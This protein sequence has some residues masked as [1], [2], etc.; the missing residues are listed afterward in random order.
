MKKYKEILLEKD[1]R[2]LLSQVEAGKRFEKDSLGNDS[3]HVTFPF[4]KHDSDKPVKVIKPLHLGHVSRRK[5][6][7]MRGLDK[8]YQQA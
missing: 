4:V 6:T 8:P 2:E 7:T 1:I 5:Y 3:Y